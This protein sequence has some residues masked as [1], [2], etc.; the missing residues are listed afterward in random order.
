MAP[1]ENCSF[2][3]LI[4]KMKKLDLETRE[5]IEIDAWRNAG[6][7]SENAEWYTVENLANKAADIEIFLI[8]IKNHAELIHR[9]QTIL[10]IGGGQGWASCVLKYLFPDKT[11]YAS[12]IGEDAIKD[13]TY[14]EYIY[15]V[16][17]DDSFAC[18]SYDIPLP[19]ESLDLV[20]C[21]TAAHHFADIQGT[22]HEASRVLR[23]GGACL[24][25][26]EPSCRK[27]LYPLASRRVIK[28]RPE[29]PEDV[30]V[31]KDIQSMGQAEGFE[32]EV[33]FD[34]LLLRRTP[35]EM[36]YYYVLSKIKPLQ[37]VLP[38]GAD[39]VFKK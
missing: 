19:N 36:M 31:F 10:E 18:R 7:R 33:R 6:S 34:P 21:Y 37:N 23:E 29:V 20:Y 15:K 1:V 38:C 14:W 8:K 13:I 4:I 17:I 35:K 32:V 28:K 11:I 12:D 3:V 5:Q 2:F 22:I 16:K 9:S 30:L 26:Q 27:Y 39:Y 25:L 24:F